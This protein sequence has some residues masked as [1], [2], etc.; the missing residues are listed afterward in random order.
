MNEDEKRDAIVTTGYAVEDEEPPRRR[1]STRRP[2]DDEPVRDADCEPD[3]PLP[4]AI[5]KDPLRC[6]CRG[7]VIDRNHPAWAYHPFTAAG[8]PTGHHPDCALYT[9]PE[10]PIEQTSEDLFDTFGELA[11]LH[12]RRAATRPKQAGFDQASHDVETGVRILWDLFTG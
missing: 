5:N 10:R 7:F 6:K 12:S 1:R 11:V 3:P 9:M 8:E 4:T 2:A